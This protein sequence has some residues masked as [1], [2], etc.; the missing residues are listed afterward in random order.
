MINFYYL[1]FYGFSILSLLASVL[2]VAYATSPSKTEDDK[3]KH[4]SALIAFSMIALLFTV[5]NLMINPR[6]IAT[7]SHQ[8]WMELE[9]VI[10]LT[11]F[12]TNIA[13]NE[14]DLL[15]LTKLAEIE[16]T[17]QG[18]INKSIR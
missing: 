3:E 13:N 2:V 17:Y 10:T 15:I 11:V 16:E 1:L 12:D 6:M 18:F 14:K 8:A 4:K 5:L 7:T 9:K